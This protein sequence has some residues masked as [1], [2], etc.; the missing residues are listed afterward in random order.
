MSIQK[1][2]MVNKKLINLK[3]NNQKGIL[4]IIL[5]GLVWIIR[6]LQECKWY[7]FG[8]PAGSFILQPIFFVIALALL[9][10]GIRFLIKNGKK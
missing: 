6:P 8:C 4:L 7:E 5:A 1:N 9:V 2:K 10:G 3:D